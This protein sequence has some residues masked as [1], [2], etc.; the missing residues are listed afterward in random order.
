MLASR[1]TRL[2]GDQDF[3]RPQPP[4]V[5]GPKPSGN[6]FPDVAKRFLLVLPLGPDGNILKC[7]GWV[8]RPL[9][10]ESALNDRGPFKGRGF[11]VLR[12]WSSSWFRS[13]R[14]LYWQGFEC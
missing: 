1:A 3:A 8:A 13:V 11:R 7:E 9:A 12:R 4:S 5:L 10:Q 2:N 6:G 14:A